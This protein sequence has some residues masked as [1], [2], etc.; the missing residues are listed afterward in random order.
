MQRLH[1][2][3]Q[4]ALV[5][6]STRGAAMKPELRRGISTITDIKARSVVDPITH[7]WHWKGGFGKGT[8]GKPYPTM[9]ALD[10]DRIEKRTMTATLAVWNIAHNEGARGRIIYR[11]CCCNDCVNPAHMRAGLTKK[12]SYRAVVRAGKLVG[13]HKNSDMSNVYSSMK[14]R[15]V[16][17]VDEKTVVA[18]RLLGPEVTGRYISQSF[19][20]P[21]SVVSRIR[22]GETYK[23]I[24]V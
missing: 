12:E 20:I 17:L 16:K 2:P 18:I 8:N 1:L 11:S 24:K 6:G 5:A 23:H 14:K 21:E 10:H 13:R 19:G 22:R 3:Q 4:A 15:G 7:C 9:H